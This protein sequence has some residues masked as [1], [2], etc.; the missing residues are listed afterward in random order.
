MTI[1]TKL[2]AMRASLIRLSNVYLF[3]D[4]GFSLGIIWR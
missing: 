3:N 4:S 1:F 2:L